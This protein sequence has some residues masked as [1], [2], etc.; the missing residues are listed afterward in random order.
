MNRIQL[1]CDLLIAYLK[2]NNVRHMVISS[3]TR[4]VPFI[5]AI[6]SDDYFI[7]HS[8][9]DERNA[10]FYGLGISQ[11][12][13][14][15]VGITC[16]SGTAASNYLSGMTEAFYSH[17]PLIAITA[18][19]SM[20][21]LNQLETQKV[22][23]PA[24]FEP[25]VHKSVCLPVIKDTDDFWYAKRLLDEVFLSMRQRGL[26]P[27]HINLPIEGTTDEITIKNNEDGHSIFNQLRFFSRAYPERWQTAFEDITGYRRIL[28]VI[29]QNI[30]LC[31][32]TRAAIECFC[33]EKRIPI[34]GDNLSNFRSDEMV[35]SQA[36]VKSLNAKTF[37]FVLPELVISIG[38]NFQE[39]LKDML[40]AHRGEFKH[41]IVDEGG[42][43]RDWSRSLTA[44]F[45][46]DTEYF[47]R[48]FNANTVFTTDGSYLSLWKQIEEAA[49]LPAEMPWTNFYTAREF[50]KIIPDKSILHLAIL[51][52]TRLMQFFRLPEHIK[53]T[54]NASSFGIDG[55][56]PTLLGQAKA[57]PEK[58]A[59]L[60]IGD[61]SFFY[62]MNALAIRGISP[63][64]R[65]LLSNNGGGAEFHIFPHIQKDDKIDL[66]IG[67]AHSFI[68]KQWAE[69]AGF[70]YLSADGK[71]RLAEVLPAFIAAGS[72]KPII[73][74]V[75]TDLHLDGEYC[76]DVY[77][78]LEKK[79]QHVLGDLE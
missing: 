65:I 43:V 32:K 17:T 52:S 34:L 39:R 54:C 77:R 69:S 64:V 2:Q 8:V 48:Q 46:S 75:F 3:G 35:F 18:D 28:V 13:N 5:R 73:L 76:L 16:T 1:S 68:A 14:A 66:H 19:R 31:D 10:A 23:Q 67:A 12:L 56:L 4:A 33:H 6:E 41:W 74:E 38:N 40:K 47:F 44:L 58:L 50:A 27:I 70:R 45:E 29:G 25:V 11:E 51:N 30:N 55:C 9:V 15:P 22:N 24:I 57:A 20:Q 71:E 72:D 78:Y 62:G 79:V 21:T 60:F 26:G 42:I 59:F 36:T 63:N 7:C 53:I 61:L 37:R 49:K